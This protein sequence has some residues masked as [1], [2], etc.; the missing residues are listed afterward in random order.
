MRLP[1]LIFLVGD[2]HGGVGDFEKLRALQEL[3]WGA[4]IG[5][6]D[7]IEAIGGVSLC[8]ETAAELFGRA[9]LAQPLPRPCSFPCRVFA[10][11]TFSA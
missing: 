7:E 5:V 10:S 3:L 11:D 1:G 4:E 2:I 6:L 9:F 8:D